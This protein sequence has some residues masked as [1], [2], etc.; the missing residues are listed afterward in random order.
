MSYRKE[1]TYNKR[2]LIF[3]LDSDADESVCREIFVEREYREVEAV[4]VAAGG[5][6]LDI[7]AHKGMFSVYVRTLNSQVPVFAFE[8]EERNFAALKRNL[9][10]NHVEGVVAKNVA[11]AGKDE[12]RKLFLSADSHNHSFVGEG[13]FKQVNAMSLGRILDR[14][15]ANNNCALVK[16]DCEGAE[17]EI[18]ENLSAADFKKV[19]VFYVEY[20]EYE[21]EVKGMNLKKLF[22]KYGFKTTLRVSP[23]DKRMG[24]IL[25]KKVLSF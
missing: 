10:L 3:E 23:Y 14:V 18:L 15:C 11:V 25:A 21:A 13:E 9:K 4:I 12:V 6:I 24:F 16:M 5:P 1:L 7:G 2:K 20:H 19:D 17:F 8:P 22:E